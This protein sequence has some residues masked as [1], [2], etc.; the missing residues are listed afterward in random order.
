[1]GRKRVGTAPKAYVDAWESLHPSLI[2]R[3]LAAAPHWA[4]KS[5]RFAFVSLERH[6]NF[7]TAVGDDLYTTI[8]NALARK[9]PGQTSWRVYFRRV[10]DQ[11][12]SSARY[13]FAAKQMEGGYHLKA[14]AAIIGCSAS[15]IRRNVHPSEGTRFVATKSRETP[16]P[17]DVAVGYRI[18][19]A[20]GD[21]A[22]AK[23]HNL[24]GQ[25]G[26][27]HPLF[28]AYEAGLSGISA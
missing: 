24:C 26:A 19:V 2:A 13:A 11:Q 17:E 8:G 12:L 9:Y 20:A 16:T 15:S 14:V 25:V 23:N 6:T 7:A 18:A 4:A 28:F 21:M 22:L 27:L 3:V 5:Q 10:E 1:V